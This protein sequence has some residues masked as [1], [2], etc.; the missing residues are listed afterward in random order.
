MSLREQTITTR[1]N[2]SIVVKAVIKYEIRNPDII[3]LE[4]NDS[5]DA[6]C[7]MT[8]GII[9]NTFITTEY[10]D[11]NS[12]TITK[13]IKDKVK[14]EVEKWGVKVQEVTITDLG[15]MTSLRLLNSPYGTN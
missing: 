8:Q 6:I 14:K 1:D 9:R 11:C 7:D 4:V 2:I 5:L 10:K 12:E 15:K 13:T 3:L